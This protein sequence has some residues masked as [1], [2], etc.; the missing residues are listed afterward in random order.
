MSTLTK[1]LAGLNLFVALLLFFLA[2]SVITGRNNWTKLIDERKAVRD[3]LAV[4][5][6][7]ERDPILLKLDPEVRRRLLTEF[8]SRYQRR[9]EAVRS[10]TKEQPL[11]EEAQKLIREIG[12]EDYRRLVHR[13][14]VRERPKTII[15]E[16]NLATEKALLQDLRISH[17]TEI[18]NLEV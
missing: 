1:I 2:S 15:E 9:Q 13:V 12:P 5:D 6:D 10:A 7:A 4:A 17:E 14:L 11:S 18:A 3:G 8:Q 16:Q